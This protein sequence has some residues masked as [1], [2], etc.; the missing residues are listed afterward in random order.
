MRFIT[1]MSPVEY[2]VNME[3]IFTR[4]GLPDPGISTALAT[5]WKVTLSRLLDALG[6]FDT[7]FSGRLHLWTATPSDLDNFHALFRDEMNGKACIFGI[8]RRTVQTLSPI[9]AAATMLG[10]IGLELRLISAKDVDVHARGTNVVAARIVDRVRQCLR[11]S[12]SLQKTLMIDDD[13]SYELH[14]ATTAISYHNLM[15]AWMALHPERFSWNVA[16]P[17]LAA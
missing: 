13:G 1:V 9:E 4:S 7:M 17:R 6:L 8:D 12:E 15:S 10:S 16:T 14:F 11:I 5:H 3:C 2:S